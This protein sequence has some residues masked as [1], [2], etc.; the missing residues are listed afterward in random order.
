[1]FEAIAR[2]L[3]R[4]AE[5]DG[6]GYPDWAARYIPIV[7]KLRARLVPE[8]LVIEIGANAAGL[9]AFTRNPVCVVDADETQLRAAA[10]RPNVIAVRADARNLPFRDAS[11]GVCVCVDMLEHLPEPARGEAIGE[12]AR[13]LR[14]DGSAAVAFPSGPAS[15][16]VEKRI[17]NE[18]R[19]LTGNRLPWL[20]EHNING[21]PDADAVARSCIDAFGPAYRVMRTKNVPL[22]VWVWMWRVMMCGWPGRGN[23]L[24]QA[25]LRAVTP[26][27]CR[28]R[29]G[30]CYRTA[31]W[32]EPN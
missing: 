16:K 4:Y 2:A 8:S 26:V 19:E 3:R 28:L 24:A 7:P 23:A 5:K 15:S 1:M 22:P 25:F 17:R 11:A 30:T 29:F 31:I 18:Y 21:L 12:I 13:I 6:R 27:V 32:I 14:K 10:V 20:E 9:A